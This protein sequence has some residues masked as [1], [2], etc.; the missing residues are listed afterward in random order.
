[1]KPKVLVT[2]P[3][4]E[5]GLDLLRRATD[6]VLL[7]T[8][9]PKGHG[10]LAP[11]LGDVQGL[12]CLLSDRIDRRVMDAAPELRIIATYAVGFDNIDLVEASRRRIAVT[13]TPGVLTEATADLAWA[14]LLS[15]AR[16]VTEGE[17]FVRAGRFRGWG[18]LLLRGR[19]VYGKTLG[20][21]GAGRIG[22]AVA[23]RAVGFKMR[24]LYADVRSHPGLERQVGAVH[25]PLKELLGESDYVSL[26]VPLVEETRHLIGARELSMM[27]PT[28]YLVNTSRGAVVD[29]GALISALEAGTIRGAGLDVYEG[30]PKV[31]EGLLRLENVV[32]LP[33]LGSAT[34]ETRGDMARVAAENLLAGLEGKRP[35]D[36]INPEIFDSDRQ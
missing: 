3:I 17:R 23:R 25:V 7:E 2:A 4:P 32:L 16:R 18:P 15:V 35:P 19:G 28:A 21:V 33:H 34:D 24:V 13:N 9:E 26:H 11:L 8:D 20:I 27:K 5:E 31:P 1:M 36:I 29:E 6:L 10:E 30:E 12:L 14:L 22:S